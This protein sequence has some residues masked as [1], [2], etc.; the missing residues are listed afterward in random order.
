M[1][2]KWISEHLGVGSWK[3]LSNLPNKESQPSNEQE[4]NE[5]E[6]DL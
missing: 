2:L 3:Y 5:Q 1:D 4:L 6:L